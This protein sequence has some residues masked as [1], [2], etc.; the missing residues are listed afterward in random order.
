MYTRDFHKSIENDEHPQAVRLADYIANYLTPST[1]LDFGC[2]TGLYMKEVQTVLPTIPT[3]GFE[4]SQDA[5]DCA[6]CKNIYQTDLTE[7]VHIVKN[8]NTL[9]LCLEVLEHIEDI[10]WKQVLTNMT[11]SCDKLIFS[12]AVPGQGGTGHINCR[13]KIDWIKRFHEL[14]WVVDLDATTH[15]LH[16]MKQGYHMGW[17]V[18][19]AMVLIPYT[20]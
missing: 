14:G 1:F 20:S 8:P 9:G 5:V 4:F 7:D 11:H 19:N 15:L 10:H 3:V 12:A 13:P 17:F 6:L 16:Y 18:N 2:S